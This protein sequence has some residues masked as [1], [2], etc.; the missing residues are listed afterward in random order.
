MIIVQEKSHCDVTIL[1][2]KLI[3]NR[4][5]S[6]FQLTFRLLLTKVVTGLLVESE[7]DE[8][9]G[10]KIALCDHTFKHW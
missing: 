7:L 5:Q 2:R 4:T 8:E 3:E 10:S 1:T 6:D 9:I